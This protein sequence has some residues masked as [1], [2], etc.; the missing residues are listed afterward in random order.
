MRPLLVP[1]HLDDHLPEL[2]I[3]VDASTTIERELGDGS[4]WERM[5]RLY[6]AVAEDVA[7]TARHGTTPMVLSGD[8]TTSLGA[9]AGLQRAGTTPSIVWFDAHGDLQTLETSHSGYLGGI[10]L[11]ILLGYRPELISDALG[12][13]PVEQRRTV[14]VDGRDL[15]PPEQEFLGTSPVRQCPVAEL[16]ASTLP[17]GP[18]YLHVDLDVLRKEDVPSLVFPTEGG[19]SATAVDAA[20]AEVLASDRVVAVGLA[21]TWHPQCGSA[22]RVARLCPSL[23]G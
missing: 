15:D 3:P 8:C 9:V 22:E 17:D 14:L 16:N 23:F 6:D 18:I 12:L 10:P 21:C 5:A 20:L 4:P 13:H 7:A 11:R 2:D 1:Y 19:P